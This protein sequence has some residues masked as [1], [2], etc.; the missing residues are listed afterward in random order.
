[1][2]HPSKIS[3]DLIVQTA[4]AMIEAEGMERLSIN[5]LADALGVKTPSLYRYFEAG[6]TGLL[7]AVNAD[8]FAGL[9]RALEPALTASGTPEDRVLAVALAYRRY[10]HD[11]PIT[12]GLAYTNTIPELRPDEADQ[13]RAVLPYQ[14]LMAV[15]A[16]E[17]DSLP[18]L[19]GLLALIHGFVML[20]LA[21]QFRRGG[22]L[23]SAYVQSVRA[24]IHGWAR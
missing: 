9:F 16:G 6:K 4:R 3:R 19:R 18:A 13:E 11:N 21:Q 12:Y 22:D 2:P 24:Y 20:E 15:I 1:M 14:A 17:A 5:V 7:R 8:T 10:A 23:D